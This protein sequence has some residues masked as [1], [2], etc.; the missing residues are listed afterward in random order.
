[1]NRYF[2]LFLLVITIISASCDRLSTNAEKLSLMENPPFELIRKPY[3]QTV[4]ADSVSILWKTSNAAQ[5]CHIMYGLD[6]LITK[7]DGTLDRQRVNTM[8]EVTINGLELGKKYFYSVYTNDSLLVSGEDYYFITSPDSTANK[9]SFY[10]MGDI[11]QPKHRG[12][13]PD[14]TAYQIDHLENRPDFGLGLGDIIYLAGESEV[15]DKYLFDHM[16]L[17]NRNIP[18]YPALGNHDWRSA[19]DKNFEQE[20]KLPNNEHY[21]SFEHANAYFIALDSRDGNLYEV[22]KQSKWLKQTLVEAQSKYDWIFVYLHHN[23]KTCTYKPNYDAV[24]KLYPLFAKYNVDL[25]L[26]GQAHTFER[27]HPYDASGDVIEQYRNN[28]NSYPAINDGFIQITTGAGGKLHSAINLD[29]GD[30]CLNSLI[31]SKFH[32]GHFSLIE[33]E[34]KKLRFKGIASKDGKVYDEFVMDKN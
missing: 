20:W 23:G 8:N 19:P 14:V 28:T 9:F 3:L 2:S 16:A 11:G 15:A 6:S 18:F 17:I 27:P 24:I 13:F 33:V 31:A 21:Y 10:A 25:V 29:D 34:G 4:F 32:K 7:V 26:N 30:E 12:G 1:M 22:E 5:S